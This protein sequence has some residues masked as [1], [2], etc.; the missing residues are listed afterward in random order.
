MH[1]I[2]YVNVHTDFYPV[3]VSKYRSYLFFPWKHRHEVTMYGPISVSVD[4][5]P[6]LLNHQ[7][8]IPMHSF[9]SI[10]R[11]RRR[12]YFYLKQ[13]SGTLV[14]ST[15]TSTLTP[16]TF[17]QM[18]IVSTTPYRLNFVNV[19]WL[20]IL[21][22][23]LFPSFRRKWHVDG[24]RSVKYAVEWIRTYNED[25]PSNPLSPCFLIH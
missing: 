23:P 3:C 20:R 15:V 21:F 17:T 19:S 16:T 10:D 1:F 6:G 4:A 8:T 7:L 24:T 2:V 14:L 13:N 9:P 18:E 12:P 25:K 11:R 22:W 5:S